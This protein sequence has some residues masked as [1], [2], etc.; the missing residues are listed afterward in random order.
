MKKITVLVATVVIMVFVVASLFCAFNAKIFASGDVVIMAETI[1]D[2]PFETIYDIPLLD[3][4][5]AE[6][7]EDIKLS[8]IDFRYAL[9]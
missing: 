3:G 8:M 4:C 6:C 2:I 7:I 9:R 5:F 1:Y